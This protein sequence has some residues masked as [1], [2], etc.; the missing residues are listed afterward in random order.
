MQH[1]ESKEQASLIYWTTLAI[2]VYPDLKWL[3]CSLNGV[4]LT[5]VQAKIAKSQGMKAGIAD[6]FLPAKRGEYSGLYIEMKYG[7]NKLTK[8]QKEF[9]E[10][11][12]S[13]GFLTFVCYGWYE[14]KELLIKYLNQ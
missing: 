7:K 12:K 3:H 10:Y 11:V 13:Q 1:N 4:N 14:A 2:N 9:L 5:P 6:L 8:E